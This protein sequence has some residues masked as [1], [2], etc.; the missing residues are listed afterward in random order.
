RDLSDLAAAVRNDFEEAW[1]PDRPEIGGIKG[2]LA[3]AGA[4][5]AGLSGSGSAVFGLFASEEGA[6]EA[7]GRMMADGAGQGRRCFVARSIP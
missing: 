2:E 5:A 6:T 4:L 7:C 1:S 3:A